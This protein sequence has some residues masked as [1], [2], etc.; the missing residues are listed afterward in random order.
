MTLNFGNGVVAGGKSTDS[1]R[2]EDFSGLDCPDVELADSEN[3]VLDGGAISGSRS[4]MRRMTVKLDFADAYTRYEVAQLFTPGVLRTMTS[5]RGSIP[6]YVDV[7]PSFTTSN[8]TGRPV[9]VISMLSTLAYPQGIE[10]SE[11]LASGSGTFPS[12]SDVPCGCE[13]TITIPTGGGS[14]VT[15]TTAAGD[16]VLDGTFVAGEVLVVDSI[17]STRTVVYDGVNALSMFDRTTPFPELSAG[18]ATVTVLCGTTPA[19]TEC[20]WRP[21]LMGLVV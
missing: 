16:T 5:P 13:L 12:R 3:A 21:N 9:A 19:A 17:G 7:P 2:V 1:T 11:S 10:E 4:K 8:L 15:I 18:D 20:V 6:Y 14:E